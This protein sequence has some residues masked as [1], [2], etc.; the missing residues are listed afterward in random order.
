MPLLKF[1][2]EKKSASNSSRSAPLKFH[3]NEYATVRRTLFVFPIGDDGLAS[4]TIG[5]E[6][7]EAVQT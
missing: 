7:V 1:T 4:S 6:E 2:P 5:I 3:W